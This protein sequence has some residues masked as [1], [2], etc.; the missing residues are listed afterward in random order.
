VIDG[1]KPYIDPMTL[2]RIHM[3]NSTGYGYILDGDFPC[4]KTTDGKECSMSFAESALRKKYPPADF[5]FDEL[6][7]N[8]RSSSLISA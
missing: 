6:L 1:N 8:I 2:E 7:A 3:P 5:T 4:H